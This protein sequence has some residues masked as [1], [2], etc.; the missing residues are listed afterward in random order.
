MIRQDE[1]RGAIAYPLTAI[2]RGR[3]VGGHTILEVYPEGR[4]GMAR[5]VRAACVSPGRVDLAL[6]ISRVGTHQRYFFAALERE[7]EILQALDHPGVVRLASISATRTCYKERAV[8]ISGAPWFF[9]MEA[10]RGSSLESLV[11][12][13]G[14]LTL[15]LTTWLGAQ[16]AEALLYVHRHGFAH[17]DVKPDNILFRDVLGVGCAPQPVLIDFGVAARRTRQ[18]QDGSIVYMSPERLQEA[19]HPEPPE[20]A[21]AADPAKADVWSL[22]VL[23]YRMLAGRE[24]FHGVSDRSITSAILRMTPASIRGL[25]PEIPREL[26]EFVLEGCLAKDP[27]WRLGTPEV[28]RF[29]ERIDAS[30]RLERL[31]HVPGPWRRWRRRA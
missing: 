11:R 13:L 16:L 8:E 12:G 31:P 10:L 3:K 17:N 15:D 21:G 5:V 26:E 23:I 9:G 7:V 14:P 6:K 29:L 18:Q 28:V 1:S 30:G 19:R 20:T 4:G 27:H 24:P 2:R 22:G 25:R